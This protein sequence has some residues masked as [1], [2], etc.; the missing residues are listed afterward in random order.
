[1]KPDPHMASSTQ[2]VNVPHLAGAE[3][4]RVN[5]TL[6]AYLEIKRRIHDG[7]MIAGSQFLEQELA[8]M[9][10]MSR[11]PVREAL[12]RLADEKLVEVRPR[13]GARVLGVNADD[14]ADIY[15]IT[16]DLEASAAR[17]L[18]SRGIKDADL[19]RLEASCATMEAATIAKDFTA[20]MKGDQEFHEQLVLAAGNSRLQDIFSA[21]MAQAHRARLITMYGR[22]VPTQSNVDHRNLIAALKAGKADEAHLLMYEHR[23]RSRTALV[24]LLRRQPRPL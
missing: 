22:S 7:E 5:N 1:M 23:M 18:A 14:M 17:R 13:H 16:S 2:N 12:I 9:L 8:E 15:E 10:G 6:R 11:T 3:T 21:L 19:R 24:E 20:W 4:D